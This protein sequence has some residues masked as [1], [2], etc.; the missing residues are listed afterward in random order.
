MG[1]YAFRG[2]HL[3]KRFPPSLVL[4]GFILLISDSNESFKTIIQV[5]SEGLHRP[6]ELP[7]IKVTRK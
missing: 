3:K 4:G 7:R 6:L 5:P 2:F 1:K